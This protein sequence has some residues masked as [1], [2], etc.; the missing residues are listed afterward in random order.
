MKR[1]KN[2]YCWYTIK[3]WL[4][5]QAQ[6]YVEMRKSAQNHNGEDL[7]CAIKKIL[8]MAEND[9]VPIVVICMKDKNGYYIE[10]DNLLYRLFDFLNNKIFLLNDEEKLFFADIDSSKR[11]NIL[12]AQIHSVWIDIN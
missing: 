10:Y 6:G 5:A 8:E 1:L 11:T 12:N 4:D 7:D 2:Y 9:C 3:D